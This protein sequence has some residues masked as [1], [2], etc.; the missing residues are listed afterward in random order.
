MVSSEMDAPTRMRVRL[1]ITQVRQRQV[2]LRLGLSSDRVSD[3]LTG[4]RSVPEGFEDRFNEAV[5]ELAPESAG[6]LV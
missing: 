4:T 1:A 2:A 3:I 6:V 5:D